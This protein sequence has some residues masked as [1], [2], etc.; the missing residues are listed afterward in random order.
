MTQA[1]RDFQGAGGALGPWT[2]VIITKPK[3]VTISGMAGIHQFQIRALGVLGY[4]DWMDTKTFVV[5]LTKFLRPQVMRD[6]RNPRLFF[7]SFYCFI[8]AAQVVTTVSGWLSSPAD[9]SE[10]GGTG[11]RNR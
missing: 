2:S 10:F 9:V 7:G 3:R 11:I 6:P 4:T 8:V 5:A 1:V